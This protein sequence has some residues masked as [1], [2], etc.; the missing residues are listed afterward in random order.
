MTIWEYNSKTHMLVDSGADA[1]VFPASSRDTAHTRTLPLVAAN[2]TEIATSDK[3][4]LSLS[5]APG[6]SISQSFWIANVRRPILGANFF[7]QQGLLIGLAQCRLLDKATGRV[8]R[9]RGAAS[10]AISGLRISP[11][12]PFEALLLEFPEIR[13]QTFS[14]DA[15]HP[16]R[17]YIETTGPPL[18]ARPRRLT[19]S[20]IHI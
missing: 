2:G 13:A 16:V 3:R 18:H 10:P 15:K 14:G 9:G 12:G 8:H 5:F 6:H 17:H 11:V 4:T 19:L 20:L 7:I 1:C